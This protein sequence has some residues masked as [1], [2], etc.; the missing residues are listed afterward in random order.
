MY[1]GT[2]N[3]SSISYGCGVLK[4]TGNIAEQIFTAGLYWYYRF[5]KEGYVYFATKAAAETNNYL[6]RISGSTAEEIFLKA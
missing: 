6:V 4:L 1:T 3:N 5:E 2:S